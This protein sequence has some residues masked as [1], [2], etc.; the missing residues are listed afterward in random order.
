M[1]DGGSPPG[2]R[3]YFRGGY[4]ADLSDEVIAAVLEHAAPDAVADVADPPAPDGRRGRPGGHRDVVVQRTSRR[5]HVQPDRDLDRPGRGRH[6]HRRRPRRRRPP[7]HRSSLGPRYVNF[8]TDSPGTDSS[9]WTLRRVDRVR[10]AYGD[11]IYDRLARLKRQYDP[12]NLFR[13]NQ[14]V[15]PAP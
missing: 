12:A 8:D 4:L 3:N 5:L 15:R 9:A 10:S 13:R 1:L 14:N 7:S 2:L 6:A 11:Q